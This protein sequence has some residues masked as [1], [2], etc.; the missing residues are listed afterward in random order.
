MKDT[1]L[2]KLLIFFGTC[3]LIVG[4]IGIFLPILP[5]T[6]FLLLTAACY[7]KGSEKFYNW[8]LNHKWFGTYIKNYQEGNGIP[9]T[10]K[11]FAITVLW[12]TIIFS[13]FIII[14]NQ[15]LQISLISVAILVTIHLLTIKTMKKA[16]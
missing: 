16:V 8:L 12:I 4:I 9:F 3:S 15:L 5:T 13:T 7:A 14:S 6:P 1:I 10:T 2:S 11:L